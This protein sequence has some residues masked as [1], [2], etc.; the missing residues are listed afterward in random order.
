MAASA[1][2]TPHQYVKGWLEV[3]VVKNSAIVMES[4]SIFISFSSKTLDMRS[5]FEETIK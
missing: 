5:R 2:S 4:I 1:C 3:P